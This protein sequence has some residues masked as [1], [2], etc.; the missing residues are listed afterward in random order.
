[1][2]E[3]IMGLL[4]EEGIIDR[5]IA[6][7]RG[8]PGRANP[9]TGDVW[10]PFFKAKEGQE[11]QALLWERYFIFVHEYLHL[12]ENKEYQGYRNSFKFGSAAFNTLVE[13]VVSLLTETVWSAVLP[14][15][16]DPAL[17]GVIEGMYAT[18]K[19]LAQV[20]DLSHRRYRSYND[21][22]RLL[23]IVGNVENLYAAF[24]L[25]QV[26]KISGP[27]A[28]ALLGSPVNPL[29]TSELAGVIERL[30]QADPG[31]RDGV[32][33]NVFMRGDE[34][35]QQEV[36]ALLQGAGESGSKIAVYHAATPQPSTVGIRPRTTSAP[37][38]NDTSQGGRSDLT[39]LQAL[40]PPSD[41]PSGIFK[42]NADQG[43]WDAQTLVDPDEFGS[44]KNAA[45]SLKD[46]EQVVGKLAAAS[47][48][49]VLDAQLDA[50]TEA[51]LDAR[52]RATVARAEAQQTAANDDVPTDT[53]EASTAGTD[54]LIACPLPLNPPLRP[55]G[56]VRTG[57]GAGAVHLW[58]G[59][60]PDAAMAAQIDQRLKAQRSDPG[61]VLVVHGHGVDGGFA[62]V[63]G[64]LAA[65]VR[66]AR[67]R[68]SGHRGCVAGV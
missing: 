55:G 27:I 23:R 34:I 47:Y 58:V 54:P 60:K 26:E 9:E 3:V 42:T 10:I 33:I 38:S 35:T 40:L 21:V 56:V 65:Q 39:V 37:T 20:P 6:I 16:K 31:E 41:I 22:M 19:P 48:N 50:L 1:M 64:E 30:G 45:T 32:R 29:T 4:G 53:D 66:R 2:H 14:L 63:D 67:D 15:V 57:G 18:L 43:S 52:L 25:G 24:F 62:D 59:R 13:G 51:E 7:V 12:L 49:E 61:R 17:R 28:V 44:A 11:N 36:T 8:W 68:G 5:I 46:S